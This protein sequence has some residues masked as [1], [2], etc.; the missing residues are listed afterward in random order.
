MG[1]KHSG[2]D[3]AINN[4]SQPI[5]RLLQDHRREGCII[6]SLNINKLSPES[7]TVPLKPQHTVL[8]HSNRGSASLPQISVNTRFII[9][10]SGYT[11]QLSWEPNGW[12]VRLFLAFFFRTLKGRRS[13]NLATRLPVDLFTQH[14]DLL[15]CRRHDRERE[16]ERE[17][18]R[19]RGKERKREGG[20]VDC[21]ILIAWRGLQI[22]SYQKQG[23]RGGEQR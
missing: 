20:R 16:S 3:Q 4:S 8:F 19:E 18:E 14:Q 10:L 7:W 13:V 15:R 11:K 2:L 22:N 6:V 1:N 21:V 5:N 9:T 12:M 17:R 23:G